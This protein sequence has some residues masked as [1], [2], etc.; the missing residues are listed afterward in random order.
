MA[1][2]LDL[3]IEHATQKPG[4]SELMHKGRV[5]DKLREDPAWQALRDEVTARRAKAVEVLGN[6]ALRGA[7]PQKLHDEGI[8]VRGFLDG[9]KHLLDQPEKV[10]EQLEALIDRSYAEVRAELIEAAADQ[11][12]YA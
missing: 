9:C 5:F 10:Q 6:L 2:I 3:A 7:D 4:T 8:Y 1:D 12:P 11:S